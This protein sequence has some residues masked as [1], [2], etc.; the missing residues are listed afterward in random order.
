MREYRSDTSSRRELLAVGLRYATLGVLGAA[1]AS[2]FIKR[3]RLV[4]E[5]KCINDGTCR[6]C[7]IF[8]SCG[9]PEALSAKEALASAGDGGQ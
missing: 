7:A 9:R 8:D 1:A 4:H 6:G 2:A 3:R 5:G